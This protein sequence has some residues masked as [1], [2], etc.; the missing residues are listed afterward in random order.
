MPQRDAGQPGTRRISRFRRAD[1]TGPSAPP[2]LPPHLTQFVTDGIAARQPEGTSV[3]EALLFS[4]AAPHRMA[5]FFYPAPDPAE[6]TELADA[7]ELHPLLREDLLNAH[8]RPK[9]ERYGDVLFLVARSA[10]Y[11]D[12]A[13]EVDFAE[14]HILMKP[15]AVAVLCQD[16]RWIDG[17]DGT[18]FDEV[19]ATA[20][21]R[22]ERTLLGDQSLLKLGPEAV[23]YRLLDAI[24]DGYAPVLQGLSIDK[25]QIERQVFSGDAA[26]AERIYRL[27]QE[28]IDMQQAVSS[29]REVVDALQS[30]FDKY[31]IPDEL[32]TYLDDVSDHL[33]RAGSRSSDLRDSL[34]QILNVN[35]TL[36][37][38]RQNEDM[39]KI[40][41]W[42]AILFAPTLVGAIYGMNFDLMPELHWA[43]GYPMAI[44][45]MIAVAVLL[46]VIFKRGRW[47]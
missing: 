6:I 20:P 17:T 21:D 45:M 40:S 36:V 19:R 5:M 31:G 11:I 9:L 43:F 26:V 27:S 34:S 32:Q 16:K 35:A 12:E 47:M 41:G 8:Q 44:G 37:A 42:A 38:Q 10:R 15:D 2:R 4:R 22:R 46:Y 39:K 14:F 28:V 23:V 24:V 18:D 3:T 25:E 7:W 30:G 13:E 29:L 1:P 33:T